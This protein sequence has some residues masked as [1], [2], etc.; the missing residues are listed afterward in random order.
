MVKFLIV[1]KNSI[2][3][4]G[5]CFSSLL[6][7]VGCGTMEKN[8][9]DWLASESGPQNY[10]MEVID[11]E[12]YYYNDERGTSVP[13]GKVIADGWGTSVSTHVVGPDLKPLPNKLVITFFSYT[14]DKFYHGEFNLPYDQILAL[15]QEGFYAVSGQE[16]RTYDKIVAGVSPGGG[17]AVW[18]R[19]RNY[20][21]QVFYGKAK[22]AVIPWERVLDAPEF[23]REEV[24][25]DT[26][27][28][29]VDSQV[30]KEIIKNGPPLDR[31]DTYQKRYHW[32]F[33][34]KTENRAPKIIRSV[35]YINGERGYH[36]FPINEKEATKN[37][38]IPYEF[39]YY[40]ESPDGLF[41]TLKFTLNI[42]EVTAAFE[43]LEQKYNVTA[44][45]PILLTVYIF[46]NKGKRKFGIAAQ[47]GN[48]ENT[49]I[50][51]HKVKLKL[52]HAVDPKNPDAFYQD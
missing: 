30:L 2:K 11:G 37:Y 33:N 39:N 17:V 29:E 7:L 34:F 48:K 28:E 24:I 19:G 38:A 14:E 15:F 8:K 43:L 42:E 21:T 51:L 46:E 41:L 27:E 50:V 26:L 35:K 44:E 12:F 22:E 47:H 31:W 16:N 36:F 23:S 5:I 25:K 10:P 1:T 49:E 3:K 18:L 9:F 13:A 6:I 32:L 52:H 40:W 45:E 20:N 4:I